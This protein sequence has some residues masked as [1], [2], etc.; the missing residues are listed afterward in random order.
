MA[1]RPKHLLRAKKLVAR[2][3]TK[4]AGGLLTPESQDAELQQEIRRVCAYLRSGELGGC[5]EVDLYRKEGIVNYACLVHFLS[6]TC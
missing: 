2:R 3:V 4:V 1:V 5:E 6:R